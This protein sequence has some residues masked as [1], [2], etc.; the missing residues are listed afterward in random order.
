MSAPVV[1]ETVRYAVCCCWNGK[2]GVPG[3]SPIWWPLM[4]SA[5]KEASHPPY[6]TAM[7][8]FVERTTSERVIAP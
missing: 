6:S 5:E 2:H 7:H 8:H 1:N 3:R 4:E